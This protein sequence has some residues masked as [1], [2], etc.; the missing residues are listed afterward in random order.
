[1]V[2]C[3]YA[4]IQNSWLWNFRALEFRKSYLLPEFQCLRIEISFPY[5]FDTQNSGIFQPHS[6]NCDI[7]RHPTSAPDLGIPE[8]KS[9][10][11]TPE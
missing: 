6:G 2:M 10:N 8:L 9:L 3:V 4:I 5:M 11:I 1:M 7:E